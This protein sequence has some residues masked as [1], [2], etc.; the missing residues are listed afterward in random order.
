M[1]KFH[2]LEE[3]PKQDFMPRHGLQCKKLFKRLK[4]ITNF[5]SSRKLTN[6]VPGKI[7]SSQQRLLQLKPKLLL[8]QVLEIKQVNHHQ[9][10][11]LHQ[12]LLNY[13]IHSHP[14]HP[15]WYQKQQRRLHKLHLKQ[16]T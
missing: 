16:L 9:Q 7:I 2:I 14:L 6:L 11:L 13:L 15:M 12:N 8:V 10:Q 1:F 5:V 3:L 4:N